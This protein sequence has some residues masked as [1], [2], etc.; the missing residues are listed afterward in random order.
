M[1]ICSKYKVNDLGFIHRMLGCIKFLS[2]SSVAAK[3]SMTDVT[4]CNNMCPEPEAALTKDVSYRTAIGCL[5][6]LEVL[7]RIL[8][9]QLR[10]VLDRV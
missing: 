7:V 9:M 6:W 5:L 2:K 8:P 10:L 3:T 4:L 1:N